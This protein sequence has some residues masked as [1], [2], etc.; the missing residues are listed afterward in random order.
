M[1]KFKI[2]KIFAKNFS[3]VSISFDYCAICRNELNEP[4]IDFNSG[5]F[6]EKKHP[7][8]LPKDSESIGIGFCRHSY[9]LDCI[10]RWLTCTNS[11]PMCSRSWN[12]EKIINLKN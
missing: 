4:S 1:G 6:Y 8:L 12:Y 11:C 2:L 10:E 7:Y 3:N 9:H 5:N